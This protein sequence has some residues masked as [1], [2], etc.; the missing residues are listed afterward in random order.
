MNS[1]NPNS[2]LEKSDCIRELKIIHSV[3][4]AFECFSRGHRSCQIKNLLVLWLP[5]IAWYGQQFI[6]YFLQ[7]GMFLVVC[8]HQPEQG[9]E[10]VCHYDKTGTSL[11][12][13]ETVHCELIHR[14]VILDF[15]DSVLWISPSAVHALDA[16]HGQVHIRYETALPIVAKVRKLRE[17]I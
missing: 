15:L 14:K 17:K 10:I 7:E 1:I 16:F 13:P 4:Y 9:I 5:K 2:S 3:P 12:C 8:K 11:I 6:A